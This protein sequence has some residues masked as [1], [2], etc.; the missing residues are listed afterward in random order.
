MAP[1]YVLNAP[2]RPVTPR[3]GARRAPRTARGLS[4]A[5]AAQKGRPHA[6]AI[7]LM[8]GVLASLP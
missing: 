7:V 4:G 2:V 5:L 1:N 8:C 6:Q 3:A